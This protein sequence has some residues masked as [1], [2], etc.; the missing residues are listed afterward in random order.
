MSRKCIG[1]PVRVGLEASLLP[2]V[3]EVWLKARD[4]GDLTKIQKPVAARAEILMRVLAHTGI[5]AL[6]DEVTGYQHVRAEDALTKILEAFIAK[7]LQPYVSTFPPTYYEE[8][9]RLGMSRKGGCR[10][11]KERGK[12]PCYGSGAMTEIAQLKKAV[13]AFIAPAR[14][15]PGCRYFNG[16]QVLSEV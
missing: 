11:R 15:S 9:F 4:A 13:E 3:C 16:P 8:M 14:L 7:E 6:V 5:I 1:T 10:P 12:K 2:K